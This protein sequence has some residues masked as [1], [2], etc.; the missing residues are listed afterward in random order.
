MQAAASRVGSDAATIAMNGPDVS[1]MVDL[2]VQSDT[3]DALAS[4]I[5][6][7][8]DMTATTVNLLA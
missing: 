7:T 8:D 4:V 6:T 1:S 5:R 2:D 3:Y